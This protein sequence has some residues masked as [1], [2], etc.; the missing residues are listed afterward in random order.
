MRTIVEMVKSA[1]P[2][3]FHG[4]GS[5]FSHTPD[6]LENM[7]RMRKFFD[8]LAAIKAAIDAASRPVH[9]HA[10]AES[11]IRFQKI[12]MHFETMFNEQGF[13]RK[14]STGAV[15]IEDNFFNIQQ[16]W[17]GILDDASSTSVQLTYQSDNH[18]T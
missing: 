6:L 10:S 7:A 4:P 14:I 3:E 8:R 1:P 18:L 5:A 16:A 9:E 15:P 17:Q 2:P 13:F 11:I 12:R